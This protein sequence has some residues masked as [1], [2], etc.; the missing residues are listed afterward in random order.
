MIKDVKLLFN[1][2]ALTQTI[3]ELDKGPAPTDIIIGCIVP[4]FNA[5]FAIILIYR[6][7]HIL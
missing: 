6:V 7:I 1:L 5:R 4:D 3:S 2:V